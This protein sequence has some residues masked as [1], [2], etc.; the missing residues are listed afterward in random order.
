MLS[1]EEEL[2]DVLVVVELMD[3]LVSLLDVL[4]LLVVS[5]FSMA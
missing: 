5:P 4:E 1:E 2:F 3:D